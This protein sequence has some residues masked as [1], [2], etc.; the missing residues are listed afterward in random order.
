MA[1]TV[2]DSELSTINTQLTELSDHL[3]RARGQYGDGLHE[4]T[5]TREAFRTF[6]ETIEVK[7]D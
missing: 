1:S 4:A 5:R 3:A 6:E 7:R 2:F